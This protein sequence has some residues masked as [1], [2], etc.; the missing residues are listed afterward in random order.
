M[1]A[2][3]LFSVPAC[4]LLGA[5]LVW[6]DAADDDFAVATG[7]YAQQRWKLAG[8][9]LAEFIAKHP[10]DERRHQARFLLA[11]SLVQ[12]GRLEQAGPLFNQYLKDDPHGRYVAA[13]TFRAGEI[14]FLGGDYGR[15]AERLEQFCKLYPD[16]RYAAYAL[17]Y[18]GETALARGDPAAAAA[19]FDQALQKFP[20]GPMQDE[21]R[22]GL[23]RALA[24]LGRTEEAERYLTA[25]AGKANSPLADDAQ[26]HLGAMHYGAGRYEQAAEAL[27]AFASRWTDSPLRSRA[28]LGRGWALYKSRRWGEARRVFESLGDDPA[29][30]LEAHYWAAMTHREENDL[31][32]AAERLAA[33]VAAAEQAGSPLAD[34]ARVQTGDVLLRLGRTVEAEK[35]FEPI[36]RRGPQGGR[37][38]DSALLGLLRA[39]VEAGR[40]EAADALFA[41][42]QRQCAES[43]LAGSAARW[44]AKSL[45]ARKQFEAAEAV[46][47]PLVA[48]AQSA[49]EDRYLYAVAL[50]GLQRREEALRWVAP[51]AESAD[52]RLK[53]DAQLLQGALLVALG[54]YAEAVAPLE[55]FAAANPKGDSAMK[56]LGGLAVALARTGRMDRAKQLYG[57]LTNEFAEHPLL[58]AVIEQLAEAAYAAR[59]T[60][61]S[62][63]LFARLRDAGRKVPENVAAAPPLIGTD[64]A[65]ARVLSGLAWSQFKAGRYA[66]AEQA[67]DQILR[68]N[69]PPTAAET[70][71]AAL[72]RGYAL[73]EL[74]RFEAALAMFDMVVEKYPE[75]SQHADA[76]YS[77][78]RLRDRLDQD[79]QA[80]E[81]YEKLA[82]LHPRYGQIDRVL[83]HWAWAL[84]ELKRPADADQLF[85][86]LRKEHPKSALIN[87]V[88]YRLAQRAAE[89]GNYAR[90]KEL[91]KELAD[92][93]PEE[94]LR[95]AADLLRGQ[96]AV[97]EADWPAAQSVFESLAQRVEGDDRLWVEFWWAESHYRQDQLDQAER[98]LAALASR[99]EKK[100]EAWFAMVPLRRAQILAQRGRWAEARAMAESVA[101]NYPEFELQ[102]EA[103]F[104]I[105][106]CLHAEARLDDARAAFA[107]VTASPR[108]AKTETA[109]KA[110]WW[111]AETYFH[112][113]NYEAALREYLRL[114]ILYDFPVWRA[115]ALL[116]AGKCQMQLGAPAEAI[117]LFER[118]LKNYPESPVAAEAKETLAKLSAPSPKR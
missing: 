16:D 105:G 78:A 55:N 92:A 84:R 88:R 20:D 4:L 6:G 79:V 40:H 1:R 56:A 89:G 91:L 71:E 106:R 63:Q 117:A 77:A 58:P 48:G 31:A 65:R 104:L 47:R 108:G 35:Y 7:H 60:E 26:F 12:L 23:G 27:G 19:R 102:Y 67:F 29:V 100:T 52:G 64:A 81:L 90:A 24:A 110:Q 2:T 61:F 115:A 9:A 3:F 70:A 76:M 118:L 116:Q 36:V 37:W 13:A 8:E 66:E 111:I 68:L 22:L 50:D 53:T 80:V 109:A 54:R 75:S 10:A 87:D 114:E 83:Y 73:Q 43:E 42:F 72:M 21:C 14:A 69:P 38:F 101:K 94:K 86:R 97:A 112:Q 30:G 107:R 46:L 28:L 34:E 15:A 103:D 62:A 59:D 95:N 93:Q 39:A 32:R 51:L 45:L 18:L 17:P 25:L 57:R 11:E 74:E 113:K 98:V 99:A 5:S 82:T 85:E 33:V 49:E 41:D 44:R 96:V